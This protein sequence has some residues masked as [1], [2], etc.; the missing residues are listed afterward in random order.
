[1]AF[2]G[3]YKFQVCKFVVRTFQPH[4]P[5]TPTASRQPSAQAQPPRRRT[6]AQARSAPP[7]R[8]CPSDSTRSARLLYP[9]PTTPHLNTDTA[10]SHYTPARCLQAGS[11]PQLPNSNRAKTRHPIRIRIK[12]Q[13][14]VSLTHGAPSH[15][16]T[17]LLEQSQGAFELVTF[18]IWQSQPYMVAQ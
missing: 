4:I 17:Q 14:L 8:C 18:T 7:A 15:P 5:H 6:A 3:R 12:R 13:Q 2:L 11:P 10:S 1:M 16:F 9:S